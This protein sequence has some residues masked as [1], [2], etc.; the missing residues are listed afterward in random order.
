MADSTT[1]VNHTTTPN[2][3]LNMA[4]Q[5]LVLG[6]CRSVLD[7]PEVNEPEE[8]EEEDDMERLVQAFEKVTD[9]ILQAVHGFVENQ[10]QERREEQK[11]LVKLLEKV[12]DNH[13]QEHSEVTAKLLQI[14]EKV[15]DS[16]V[17]EP[18]EERALPVKL[19]QILLVAP[20]SWYQ[21][22]LSSNNIIF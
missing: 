8:P 3:T 17:R 9:K 20:H 2:N 5:Q 16:Y 18:R 10:T 12:T 1:P 19:L 21:V 14:L 6:R 15:T 7:N 13:M 4:N 22:S 11:D